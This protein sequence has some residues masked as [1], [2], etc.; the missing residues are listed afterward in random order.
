[1]T[2]LWPNR[3]SPS[4]FR[5]NAA[6]HLPRLLTSAAR[7]TVPFDEILVYD[8]C[9]TDDTGA[10]AEA[11][12]A[13]VV[14][15]MQPGC[16]AGKNRL[17]EAT[18]CEW[19]HFHDAD[20]DITPDLVERVRPHLERDDAPDVLLLHFE[21]RDH[22]TGEPSASHPTTSPH[23]PRPRRLRDPTQGP[24]LRRLPPRGF[25]DAGGFDL[26]PTCSTTRT[27][28]STTA[29]LSRGSGSTTSL[30]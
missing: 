22:V 3:P 12:G 14:R 21:Y 18:T 16:S 24:Q 4:A 26:D 7:Q 8:D 23:A 5:H 2:C 27:S 15:A 19:I 9:S 13:N 30:R 25:L 1:M 28:R 17:A 11:Y 29:S 10:V 20:D 6:G